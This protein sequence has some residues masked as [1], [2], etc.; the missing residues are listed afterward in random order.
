MP[1]SPKHLEKIGEETPE[2]KG[3]FELE[4][5][6]R[7]VQNPRTLSDNESEAVHKAVPNPEE[8][9]ENLYPN[10]CVASTSLDEIPNHCATFL[11]RGVAKGKAPESLAANSPQRKTNPENTSTSRRQLHVTDQSERYCEDNRNQSSPFLI[12]PPT[13]ALPSLP[14]VAFNR[15]NEITVPRHGHDRWPCP[16]PACSVFCEEEESIFPTR[17]WAKPLANMGNAASW[18]LGVLDRFN[19][20]Q[21]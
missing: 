6:G 10:D 20:I 18:K 5:T 16:S 7:V 2:D 8:A 9:L 17:K 21:Y 4:N 1:Q 13:K 3:R 15:S 12:R 19:T 14:H 11:S